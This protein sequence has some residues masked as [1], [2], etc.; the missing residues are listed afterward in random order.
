[1][2]ELSRERARKRKGKGKS[3]QK[4][5][6][7]QNQTGTPDEKTG[8][9]TLSD[10]GIKRQ[11][12]QF[13]GPREDQANYVFCVHSCENAMSEYLGV[14]SSSGMSGVRVIEEPADTH[15]LKP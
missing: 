1:M 8:Q 4:G 13:V 9:R 15:E 7:N 12:V 11:R 5:N 14:P 2:D 10:F 6:H 3:P